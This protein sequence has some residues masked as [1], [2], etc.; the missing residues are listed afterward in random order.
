MSH[1]TGERSTRA[2]W[3]RSG[4]Y[5]VCN[6]ART[7]PQRKMHGHAIAA[8]QTPV[9]PYVSQVLKQR[10][11]LGQDVDG[12]APILER[13]FQFTVVRPFLHRPDRSSSGCDSH[14]CLKLSRLDSFK[15]WEISFR[16]DSANRP[17]QSAQQW[18]RPEDI[19][20][21]SKLDDQDAH[22]CALLSLLQRSIRNI[23]CSLYAR[24]V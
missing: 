2:E 17:V 14:I 5:R 3:G 20:C 12:Q 4:L 22:L 15:Q 10:S 8:N 16:S 23:I 24:Q 6:A 18:S 1:S 19:A 7:C 11:P 21:S 13:L 9:I